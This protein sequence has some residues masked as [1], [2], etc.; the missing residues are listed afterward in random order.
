MMQKVIH[1]LNQ[2]V[3]LNINVLN[4]YHH[5]KKLNQSKKKIIDL[6]WFLKFI[7]NRLY[8][9]EIECFDE[10]L[11]I[12]QTEETT[13]STGRSYTG[14]LKSLFTSSVTTGV[15][16]S[17]T[18]GIATSLSSTIPTEKLT[19]LDVKGIKGKNYLD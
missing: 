10:P 5:Q 13:G 2:Q 1:N 12:R 3:L 6:M 14:F 11:T 4:Y 17:T 7:W 8:K 15:N 9:P 16:P 19:E 18:T